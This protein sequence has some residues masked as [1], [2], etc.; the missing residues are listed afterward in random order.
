MEIYDGTLTNKSVS[1]DFG[2][3]VMK[4]YVNSARGRNELTNDCTTDITQKVMTV[5][6]TTATVID[7]ILSLPVDNN[8]SAL[9]ILGTQLVELMLGV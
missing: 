5:W 8:L 6:G 4:A 3:N 1:I 2:N 7:P 9:D